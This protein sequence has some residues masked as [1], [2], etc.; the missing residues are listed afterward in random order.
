MNIRESVELWPNS[1]IIVDPNRLSLINRKTPGKMISDLMLMIFNEE[2]LKTG[3]VTG[4]KC[5]FRKSDDP[6]KTKLNEEKTH[7]ING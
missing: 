6:P 2:E 5:N 3:S 7:A 1:N 4:K